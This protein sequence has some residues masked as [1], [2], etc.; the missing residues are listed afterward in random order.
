M[1]QR[2]NE[3]THALCV[4]AILECFD[5]KWRRGDILDTLEKYGGV[6]RRLLKEEMR[7]QSIRLRLEA[8]ESLACEMEQKIMDLLDGD[9]DA[10]DLDDVVIVPR[11]DGMTGKMRD[12]ARCSIMHQLYGHLL[13]LGLKPL[14][15]ARILPQQFASIPG[16]GQ[17]GLKRKLEKCMRKKKLRIKCAKKTDVHHAYG[18]MRYDVAIRQIRKEIP[19]AEWILALLEAL[20]QKAP[21]G[22]LIIGGYLDAWL[23]NLMMSYAIR[24]VLS[25]KGK[26]RGK[27]TPIVR[28]CP[29][30]MDDFGLLGSRM[31][32]L[33]SVARKLDV[34]LR[35]EYGMELK[36]QCKEVSILSAAE[37]K[38][39]RKMKG[40]RHSAPGLDMGGYVI[41]R[42]YTSIRRAI[43]RRIRR[44]FLRAAAEY[45][46]MGTVP[47]Y[48]ARK[49][50]SYNGYFKGTN[51]RHAAEILQVQTLVGVAR[52][53][54]A[55]HSRMA[56]YQN[57][58]RSVCKC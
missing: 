51:T 10:L 22:H 18:T 58:Q 23:F 9:A 30:Y 42:T 19:S 2:Y 36:Q 50:I 49:L 47:L 17:T 46:R 41:H 21:G 15:K 7:E 38:A 6:P 28:M 24:F 34:W 31:A 29:T 20:E 5:N 54:I 48:R 56:A 1:R 32:G 52:C 27:E 45:R 39:R 8:V 11:A 3:L 33:R 57:K 4:R 55:A 37:E 14:L 13:F 53:V 16:R 26:R 44:Q 40:A 25:H 43:Y 35:K 12:I